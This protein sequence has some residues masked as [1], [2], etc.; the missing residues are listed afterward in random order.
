VSLFDA[1]AEWMGAPAYYTGYGGSEPARSGA[2]HATIAP[3][4]LFTSADGVEIFLAIQ[5]AREWSRFCAQVLATPALADDPRFAS[6]AARVRHRADLHA[7]IAGMFAELPAEDI[8]DRLDRADIACARRNSVEE[9]INHPQLMDRDCW[10]T[11]DSPS[12]RLRALRPPLRMEGVDPV[13][14]AVPSLGQH[15]QSI[16][17]ELGFDVDTIAAWRREQMI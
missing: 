12:G 6:N 17:A 10:Q 5:N 11:I 9:F 13:M 8:L 3:Y 15:S 1:L 7:R 4:E 16:L 14:G 2:A